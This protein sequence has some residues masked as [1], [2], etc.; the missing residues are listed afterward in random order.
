YRSFSSWSQRKSACKWS[1]SLM[2]PSSTRNAPPTSC[3]RRPMVL[4][5]L[6]CVTVNTRSSLNFERP[7]P[8]RRTKVTN[9][10]WSRGSRMGQQALALM[11]LS[12][13]IGTSW[14]GMLNRILAAG[15]PALHDAEQSSAGSWRISKEAHWRYF[16]VGTGL[17]RLTE[18]K[19]D[20]PEWL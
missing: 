10:A 2:K 17:A 16:T 6:S 7:D 9:L 18:I 13:R 11:H 1:L 15:D 19:S 4:S 20:P 5:S 12:C 3:S 14:Q 8:M